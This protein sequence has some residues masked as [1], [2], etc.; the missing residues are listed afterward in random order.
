VEY[1]DFTVCLKLFKH[2][3]M[4]LLVVVTIAVFLLVVILVRNSQN[5]VNCYVLGQMM[6]GV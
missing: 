3:V 5:V 4:C 1:E 2:Q 6:C